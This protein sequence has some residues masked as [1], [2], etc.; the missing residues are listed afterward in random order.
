VITKAE[1]LSSSLRRET[2]L[3]QRGDIEGM[4]KNDV[5]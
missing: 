2:L 3:E 1:A 5:C 4:A